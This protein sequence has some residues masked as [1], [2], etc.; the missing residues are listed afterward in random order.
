M[1]N[2]GKKKSRV[3]KVELSKTD[4]FLKRNPRNDLDIFVRENRD[5]KQYEEESQGFKKELP[6][7]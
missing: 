2:V 5:C 4:S 6:F 1:K 7:C 3:Q